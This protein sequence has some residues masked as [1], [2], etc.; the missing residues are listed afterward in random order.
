MPDQLLGDPTQLQQALLNYAANAVK[1]T[2]TGRV[3]VR[4]FVQSEAPDSVLVRFE[5]E[6]T[7]IGI[8]PD[9][10]G[11]LFSAFEQADNST[12]RKY[13]GTGLGL[14]ITRKLA[15]QM[16][17]EVGVSS[18]PGKGSTFW[19]TARLRRKRAAGALTPAPVG[20]GDVMD[21]LRVI[22]QGRRLLLADDDPGNQQVARMIL[23]DAGLSVDTAADGGTAADMAARGHYALILVD[24]QMPRLNGLDATRL[25]RATPQ[26][27]HVP[28]LA[29]TANAFDEDRA[30]CLEAGM[31][32]II[33]KPVDPELLFETMLRWLDPTARPQ[34]P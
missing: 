5:V 14:A 25:I 29:M 28:I 3:T 19:F 7:G 11:R 33:A 34:E 27:R 21:R 31:S 20:S 6:D 23:E 30:R 10:L 18:T 24:M 15:E 4:S 9:A 22:L 32:D 12:T 26:G 13:G 2:D 17:G 8:P 1:F 16:Q